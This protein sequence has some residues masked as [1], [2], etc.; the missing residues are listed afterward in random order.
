MFDTIEK[1]DHSLIQHGPANDRI[2]L[3]KVNGRDLPGLV[4]KLDALAEQNHYTKIFTK[5]P[6]QTKPMFVDRGYIE[7]AMIPGFFHGE[8]EAVFL[9]RFVDPQRELDPSQKKIEEILDIAREKGAHPETKTLPDGFGIRQV[10]PDE[11]EAMAEIF[12]VVFES[13]PFP[14]HDPDYLRETMETHIAYFAAYDHRK[15]VAVSSAEMDTEAENVEMTDF[16]T[17]PDYRGKGLASCLLSH[18]ELQMQEKGIKTGYTIARALSAEMNITFA[19]A[20]Y[21]YS[22][23]LTNNTNICGQLES[24]NV[25]HKPLCT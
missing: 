23:T 4:D 17:F 1:L 7:E 8:T 16:A 20:G 21:T 22:G 25:W 12:K 24:M 13:Y 5:V 15:M 18:M 9:S 14:V 6:L 2:Y 19:R 11:A 3:M 10:R